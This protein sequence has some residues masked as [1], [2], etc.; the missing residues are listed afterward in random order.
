MRVGG[1]QLSARNGPA[2]Q[3]FSHSHCMAIAAAVYEPSHHTM[4]RRDA[5]VAL[6]SS[7]S[8]LLVSPLRWVVLLAFA[9]VMASARVSTQWRS[10]CYCFT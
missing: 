5:A 1:L 4:T 10:G 9:A 7:P 2:Q 8:H 3:A 6:L